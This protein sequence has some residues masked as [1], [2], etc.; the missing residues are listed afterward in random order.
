MTRRK[1]DESSISARASR[2]N[3]LG[4]SHRIWWPPL[5]EQAQKL[6]HVS[7]LHNVP[8]GGEAGEAPD[9]GDLRGLG[10]VLQFGWRKRTK[11]PSR[12]RRKYHAVR[13]EENRYRIITFEGAF[14]GRTLATIA[15][16]GQKKYLEGFGPKV[17]GFDQVPFGDTQGA[18]GDDRPRQRA[19]L[20]DRAD[21]G[22]GWPAHRADRG[23]CA[24][25]ASSATSTACCSS[26]TRCRPASA[27]PASSFA[28]N[29]RAFA[30]HHGDRQGHRRRLPDGRGAGGGEMRR[31]LHARH[32]RHD[33]RRQSAGGRRR[34]CRAGRGARPGF[35]EEVQ[36]KALL[37]K[38][39]LAGLVDRTRRSS[40]R[41][42]ASACSPA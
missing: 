9:R 3:A 41:C 2:L 30:G 28:M 15:A 19:A 27:A 38:Q 35:L 11:A 40:R 8:G 23:S 10:A 39:K 14:H 1:G 34:Q 37:F 12:W 6:W 36:R 20:L 29:G 16:G 21:P 5:T 22:R 33:L 25:S 18:G 4:H 32:P 13:G 7:N 17:E 31:R 26:S 24:T 42:A